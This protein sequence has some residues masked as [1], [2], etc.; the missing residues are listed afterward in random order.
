MSHIKYK[1][2]L[3]GHLMQQI[4]LGKSGLLVPNISLGCMRLESLQKED[5]KRL[6]STA[7]E[8]GINFFD[9][10]DIY[11]TTL[12]GA[13]KYFGEIFSELEIKR[14]DVLLQSKVGIRGPFYDGGIKVEYY[15]FS[16]KHII[17][18]VNQTLNNLQTDYLDSLL[19]HRNDALF[20]PEEVAEA[21]DELYTSGKVR[22]FGVS[23]HTPYQ[24]DLLKSYVKQD[25]V[26]NQLEFSVAHSGMVNFGLNVNRKNSESIDRDNG[27]IDYS[28]LK[29]M[30]IQT[31]SPVNGVNGVFLTDP[32][33]KNLNDTLKEVGANHNINHEA[34]A[35]A[36]ILRHPAKM[37]V[38]LGTMNE[39]R[40]KNYA[41]A[42]N[43]E[44]TREEW[45]EIYRQAGNNLP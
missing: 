1:N 16:K 18:T 41:Q 19:L 35:I 33:Y 23:N 4:E 17:S 12:G 29:G 38:I 20:E 37:Q 36:W 14:E 21:F 22:N 10:A 13:E 43:V 25:L 26:A 6:V 5:A 24:I 9:H 7:F 31:W 3:G 44:F 27:L 8:L 40:L 32:A 45:Y 28:R 2:H 39:A 30:T 15:D 11:G 42:S 34:A